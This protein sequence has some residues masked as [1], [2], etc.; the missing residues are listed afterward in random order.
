MNSTRSRPRR[1]FWA[2][3]AT[4]SIVALHFSCSSQSTQP[5]SDPQD[6][7]A[8]TSF[9]AADEAMTRHDALAVDSRDVS[10]IAACIPGEEPRPCPAVLTGCPSFTVCSERFGLLCPCRAC[11]MPLL[12]GVC[13]WTVT[14]ENPG[15]NVVERI[16]VDGGSQRLQEIVPG[17]CGDQD[18]G[19][20]VTRVPGIT[21]VTLCPA[22]C[23][24][25]ELDPNVTF[26]LNRGPCP[27][28]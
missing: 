2:L 20:V 6:A 26:M 25:H 14:V 1:F 21:T 12:P 11:L 9:D 15:L 5:P 22:S 19:F 16:V 7:S 18:P 13:S 28:T 4:N 17:P 10:D 23:D 3:L 24:E 8:D 27:P